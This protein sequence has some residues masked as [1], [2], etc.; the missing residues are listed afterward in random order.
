MSDADSGEHC[1]ELG[2]EVAADEVCASDWV[3]SREA[4]VRV[5]AVPP[6]TLGS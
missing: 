1:S 6:K 2:T 4:E 5:A 3:S